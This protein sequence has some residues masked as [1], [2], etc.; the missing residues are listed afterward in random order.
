MSAFPHLTKTFLETFVLPDDSLFD[1]GGACAV[2]PAK[3]VLK[4]SRTRRD[5]TKKEEGA[6]NTVWFCEACELCTLLQTSVW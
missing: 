6:E 2:W 4:E 1:G 3:R 5:K